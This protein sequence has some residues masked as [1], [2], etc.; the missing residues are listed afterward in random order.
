MI[1][2]EVF[3]ALGVGSVGSVRLEPP[4]TLNGIA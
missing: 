4:E 2:R 3:G 1:S